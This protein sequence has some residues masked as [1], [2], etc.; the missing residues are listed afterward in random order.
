MSP[1]YQAIY[2]A[3]KLI[4]QGRVSTYGDIASYL[5]NPGLSRVVGNALHVN[6][7]QG[8]VPCH[9]VVNSQGRL[10][11]NFGF[12]GLEGQRKRLE[13]E[14]VKV[15][16]GKVDLGVYRFDLNGKTGN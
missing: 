10:A 15:L 6:P 3:V 1:L 12:G 9:R 8:I 14:G 2:D 13:A 5:G 7:Y 11:R 16:D 4:P